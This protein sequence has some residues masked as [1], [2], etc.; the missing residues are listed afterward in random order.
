M[1]RFHEMMMDSFRRMKES[2]VFKSWKRENKE[3]YLVHAFNMVEGE[4]EA[5]WQ[6]GYYLKKKDRV[7][8]FI[9]DDDVK[10][11]PESEVFKKDRKAIMQ[12]DL[13]RVKTACDKALEKAKK[14]QDDKYKGHEPFK[15][16][17][18]LQHIELGQVWNITFVTRSFD[19][20]NIKIDSGTGKIKSHKLESLFS[21]GGK[22]G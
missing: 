4:K 6:F 2:A 5:G 1:G 12:L 13:A 9:V 7:V 17:V 8:T 11:S 21:F 10:K 3:S 22:A 14:L 20:L 15:E 16:V 18:L 19:T